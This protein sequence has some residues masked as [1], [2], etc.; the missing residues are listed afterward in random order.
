LTPS[1][2][3]LSPV[4]RRVHRALLEG[5]LG[6]GAVPDDAAL[7]ATAGI[8]PADLPRHLAALV[9]AD[10]L[11]LD[12]AGRPTCLYPLSLVPTPHVVAFGGV[13]RHAMCSIDALGVAA[14]LGRAVTIEGSC[15]VCRAP[16]RIDVAPGTIVRAEP[17][18]AVVV[19][20]GDGDAS[21]FDACCPFTLF[22]CSPAHGEAAAARQPD[23]GVLTLAE[24]LEAGE[25]IF[26]DFL[27]DYLPARRRRAPGP[28]PIAAP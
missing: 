23:T 4:D 22:A 16:V 26:G 12:P 11:A 8:D 21:G 19:A 5:V 6:S 14:M 9:A 20:R 7:A 10:Y 25:T 15:A 1:H 24:G 13:R 3:T 17:T 18:E 28:T 27:A 2:P